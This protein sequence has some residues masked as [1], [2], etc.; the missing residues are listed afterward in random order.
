MKAFV[1]Q[2]PGR[3]VLIDDA[4]RPVLEEPYGAILEPIVVAPCTSDVNTV[5]G[6]GSRK[7]DNLIL[8]HECI[9]RVK[10][11]AS[12]V[13]DFQIG[14]LV[15]VPAITPD[16]RNVEIQEGNDRHAGRPFSGNALGRSIP[17]V[18]A[19]EFAIADADTTLAKVPAG[20]CLEDALMC[21][22]MVTTGFTGVEAAEI[23]FGDTVAVLGIGAVG[24]MAVQGAALRGAAQIYAVGTREISV[25][26]AREFGATEVLS[27]RD[28]DIKEQIMARTQGRGADAVFVCGGNDQTFSEAVEIARYGIGRVVNLKHY[29]GEGVIGIPKFS[30]G[31]GM[32]GKTIYLELCK[33][34]RARMERLLRMVCAGRMQ[35]GR[36]ITHKR[37]GFQS[38][39]EG[40][41]LM[42]QKPQDLI[43]V[44]VRLSDGGEERET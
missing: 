41:E 3:A 17:G 34:G 5:Y 25:Q 14:D 30:G 20:V 29:A 24:L 15:A 31:R 43:K 39:S 6:S 12:R 40:L 35:P 19:E 22:D 7:P 42:R 44:M 28:G 2:G 26:R 8:G 38:L 4:P 27:Y 16:W 37:R 23:Q 32:A 10:A 21:V 11:V 13:R 33:G 18:F 36:M 9:A 1:L